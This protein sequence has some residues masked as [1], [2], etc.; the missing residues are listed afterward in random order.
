MSENT[1]HILEETAQF[2]A[3]ASLFLFLGLAINGFATAAKV[4][5]NN[6]WRQAGTA[7]VAGT[8]PTPVIVAFVF[9]GVCYVVAAGFASYVAYVVSKDSMAFNTAQTQAPTPMPTPM[10]APAP[11]PNAQAAA[12]GAAGIAAAQD[13]ERQRRRQNK[14]NTVLFNAMG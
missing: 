14:L 8:S 12:A 11:T 1:G 4:N 3:I 2:S 5:L 10:P 9:V 13:R 7:N 6:V